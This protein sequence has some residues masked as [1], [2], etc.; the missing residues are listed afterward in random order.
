MS[1]DIDTTCR[2]GDA[3]GNAPALFLRVDHFP[4]G[5]VRIERGYARSDTSRPVAEILFENIAIIVDD[6]RHDAG[7]AVFGG[8]GDEPE[9]ADHVAAHD[10]IPGTAGRIRALA[11]QDLVVIAVVR[12]SGADAIASLRCGRDRFA[13]GTVRLAARR[14]PVQAVLLAGRA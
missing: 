11:C 9:A 12:L 6:E 14:R 5:M 10:V 7:V 4:P 8:I 1:E 2:C 13:K 3:D